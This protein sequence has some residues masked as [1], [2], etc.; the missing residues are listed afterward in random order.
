MPTTKRK[1]WSPKKLSHT[2]LLREEG[3]TYEEIAKRIGGGVKTA[4]A[5][6]VIRRYQ[7]NGTIETASGLASKRRLHPKQ[8]DL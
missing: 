7:T 8:C 4:G 3:D 5:L 6:K 1:D 2:I